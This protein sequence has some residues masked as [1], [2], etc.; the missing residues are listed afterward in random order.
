MLA[1]WA[2]MAP[3]FGLGCAVRRSTAGPKRLLSSACKCTQV[4]HEFKTSSGLLMQ[5][6]PGAAVYL[7]QIRLVRHRTVTN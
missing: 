6:S 1:G 2:N 4:Q 7:Y 3:P 5:N